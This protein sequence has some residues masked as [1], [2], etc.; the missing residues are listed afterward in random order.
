MELNITLLIQIGNFLITY[1]VL[2]KFLFKPSIASIKSKKEAK[3]SFLDNITKEEERLLSEQQ[4]KAAHLEKFQ[5]ETK[6]EYVPLHFK[7]LV[8][9][10][11]ITYK[12]DEEEVERTVQEAKDF[13]VKRTPR[14]D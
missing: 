5:R 8:I 4:R 3:K 6:K 10:A 14:V 12:R 13:I 9:E 2:K 11:D 1:F 7:P